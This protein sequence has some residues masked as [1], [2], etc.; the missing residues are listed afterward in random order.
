MT[1]FS[2]R[3]EWS[4][5][6]PSLKMCQTSYS[7]SFHLDLSGPHSFSL[8]L[9]LRTGFTWWATL[10]LFQYHLGVTSHGL[11]S[12]RPSNFRERPFPPLVWNGR[13]KQGVPRLPWAHRTRW[14]SWRWRTQT[15]IGVPP[16]APKHMSLALCN[17]TTKCYCY[18][19]T[20]CPI[21]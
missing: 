19:E 15:T 4:H 1:P 12:L 7:T 16:G 3:R 10:R 18:R 9:P 13:Q 5:L 17:Q 11:S 8:Y 6:T 20:E 21:Y 2:H 14:T